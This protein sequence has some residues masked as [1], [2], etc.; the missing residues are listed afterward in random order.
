MR[1]LVTRT[2]SCLQ[3]IGGTLANA[4]RAPEVKQADTSYASLDRKEQTRGREHVAYPTPATKDGMDR[5]R[6]N[7][8]TPPTRQRLPMTYAGYADY[9]RLSEIFSS[10]VVHNILTIVSMCS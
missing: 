2:E 8:V 1:A 7:P 4:I 5:V 6:A 3:T 9:K 10:R